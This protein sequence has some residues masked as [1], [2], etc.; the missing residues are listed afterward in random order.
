MKKNILMKCV[1]SVL[2]VGALTLTILTNRRA[3]AEDFWDSD[4]Y[5]RGLYIYGLNQYSEDG[6]R[7][8]IEAWDYIGAIIEYTWN[9]LDNTLEIRNNASETEYTFE[10]ANQLGIYIVLIRDRDINYFETGTITLSS[11]VND[12]IVNPIWNISTI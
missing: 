12:A 10:N 11:G 1:L 8:V 6:N 5:N 7:I 3:K 2:M 9:D 4:I